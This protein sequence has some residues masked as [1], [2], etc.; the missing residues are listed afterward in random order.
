MTKSEKKL[1]KNKIQIIFGKTGSGKTT[2]AKKLIDDSTRP[3]LIIWDFL[4]EYEEFGFVVET[5]NE[6]IMILEAKLPTNRIVV[7]KFTKEQFN[8]LCQAV[9]HL[10]NCLFVVEEADFVCS[11]DYI[12]NGFGGLLRYGRHYGIDILAITRRPAE[13][14][15]LLTAMAHNAYSFQF[16]EPCDVKYIST[17]FQIE[18]E[19]LQK[20]EMYK[21]YEKTF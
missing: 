19:V 18:P 8:W 9:E 12:D 13:I 5:P 1:L 20:L 15:R 3:N 14:N 16:Q 2:L 21:Y 4:L 7:R 10:G 6:L 17:F 11:S